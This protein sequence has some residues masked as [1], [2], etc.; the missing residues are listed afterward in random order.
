MMT[1]VD[2]DEALRRYPKPIAGTLSLRPMAASD[3]PALLA[4]FRR[5]PVDERQLFRESAEWVPSARYRSRTSTQ[6]LDSW[7]RD[8]RFRRLNGCPRQIIA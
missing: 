4:F 3:E 5:I 7:W 1:N 2:R 6:V 8:R